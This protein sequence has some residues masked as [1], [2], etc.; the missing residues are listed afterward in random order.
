MKARIGATL[1]LTLLL[2]TGCENNIQLNQKTKNEETNI[3]EKQEKPEWKTINTVIQ[4]NTEK[5]TYEIFNEQEIFTKPFPEV[6]Q[7]V[8]GILSFRSGPLRKNASIGYPTITEETLEKKW[9][10]Q[11]SSSPEWGGGAGWVGQA[12]VIN[13]KK[14]EIEVMNLYPDFKNKDSLKEVMYASLDGRI[15]FLDFET[16]K[17]TRQPIDIGNPIKGSVAL[18]P[19]GYP[20]LYVGQGIPQTGQIGYRI[21]SLIDG[22]LMKFIPGIDPYAYRG[23]GAFDGAALIDK[24]QDAMVI[25][26]ENGIMYTIKLN[27]SYKPEESKISIDP[28]ISKYRYQQKNNAYQGMENSIAVYKNIAYFADNGGGVQAFDLIKRK[29]IWVNEPYD[30]TDATIAIEEKDGNP[31]IYVGSEIDKQGSKGISR[32]Q[33]LNGLDGT[34][35]WEKEIPGFSL[36]GDDPVNGGMLASPIVGEGPLEGQII[37]N[38]SRYK[39]F[40]GGLLIS[41]D[42]ETGEENWRWE[43]PNY[44]WSSPVAVYTKDNE[45]YIIQGDSVGNMNL[46]NH[47]GEL[48]DQVNLGANIEAS[49]IVVDNEIIVASRGGQIF[50]ISI[51]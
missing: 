32:I 31:Y 46:L 12:S 48:L 41:Y 43:M 50:S 13:W 22:S 51:K 6:Y 44:S 15:Y 23:W 17:Q 42:S 4:T 18:D 21:F 14:K 37:F 34:V 49:P 10:F 20:I 19:R 47:K 30:D 36:I 45:A 7:D 40:N 9:V 33:K 16:G 28:V 3:E 2:S 11:T 8:E 5:L 26:G 35:I 38:I 24:E 27:T 25:A 29:P 39:T 1:A